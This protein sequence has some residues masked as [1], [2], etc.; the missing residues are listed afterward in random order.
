LVAD[1][2]TCALCQGLENPA[3]CAGGK[4]DSDEIGV[5][6]G[7]QGGLDA[8]VMIVGQDWGSV[9]NFLKQ[10]GIDEASETIKTL[11]MLLAL[12]GLKAELPSGRTQRGELFC[13]N[14]VLCLKCGDDQSKLRSEWI[15]N[16]CEHF[17][18]RQIE[19]IQPKLV[20]CLASISTVLE[21][22]N[23][24]LE[25]GS[26]ANCTTSFLLPNQGIGVGI[27]PSPEA[28]RYGL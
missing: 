8:L 27:W 15:R 14:T 16:C 6:S 21:R 10:K 11:C 2:K 1:R 9:R 22:A 23:A 3:R 19:T 7:W 17:L 20:V 4:Y 25:T 13:T 12:A 24:R 28:T 18:R 5:W 26:Q